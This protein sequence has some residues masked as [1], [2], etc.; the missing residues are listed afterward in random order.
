MSSQVLPLCTIH[1]TK[2][3][4]YLTKDKSLFWELQG[5]STQFSISVLAYVVCQLCNAAEYKENK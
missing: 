1:P 2:V 5:L 3:I 4:P